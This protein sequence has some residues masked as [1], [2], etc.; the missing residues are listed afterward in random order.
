MGGMV[1]TMMPGM[2]HYVV[3]CTYHVRH[4]FY[5]A[6][7]MDKYLTYTKEY[8]FHTPDGV[9]LVVNANEVVSI[10]SWRNDD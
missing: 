4:T 1:A 8:V 7:D 5:G 10:K 2:R 3:H 6:L 9:E